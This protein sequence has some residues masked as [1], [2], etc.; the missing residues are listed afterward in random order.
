[1][2]CFWDERLIAQMRAMI[3]FYE[4]FLRSLRG[5]YI[6]VFLYLDVE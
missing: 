5:F 1:M 6:D 4:I 3:L 2:G